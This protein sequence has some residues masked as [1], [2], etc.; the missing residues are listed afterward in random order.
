MLDDLHELERHG[1]KVM[2]AVAESD[3][4]CSVAMV[5]GDN[6]GAHQLAG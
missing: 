3:V 4:N 1:I 2:T 5:V 6:K